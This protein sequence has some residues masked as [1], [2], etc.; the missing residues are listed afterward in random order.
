[1]AW[2]KS[3]RSPLLRRVS[4]SDIDSPGHRLDVVKN[5]ID[6][7]EVRDVVSVSAC[8]EETD[9]LRFLVG[10]ESTR[11]PSCREPFG[12]VLIQIRLYL[13]QSGASE[14]SFLR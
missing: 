13:P 9:N 8:K 4:H 5:V 14:F 2:K 1:M 12:R 3:R 11:V 6:V 10:D 7:H